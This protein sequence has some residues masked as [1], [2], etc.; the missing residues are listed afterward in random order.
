M[1]RGTV[2]SPSTLCLTWRLIL[3]RRVSAFSGY[4]S[5]LPAHHL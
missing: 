4:T 3:P 5:I 2:A 1:T